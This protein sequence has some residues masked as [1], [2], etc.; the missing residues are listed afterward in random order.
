MSTIISNKVPA[1]GGLP[2]PQR[3]PIWVWLKM[4]SKGQK[5]CLNA[6]VHATRK[7]N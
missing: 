1:P 3:I 7:Y 2:Y 5:N 6:E 4:T